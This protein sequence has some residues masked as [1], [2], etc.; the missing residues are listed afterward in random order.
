M[1]MLLLFMTPFTAPSSPPSAP[2]LL[3][4]HWGHEMPQCESKANWS[5]KG[6][7]LLLAMLLSL[8]NEP[9]STFA[10][11]NVASRACHA[12]LVAYA[13]RDWIPR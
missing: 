4:T 5:G 10:G 8:Q 13:G 3:R 11:V 9:R 7:W 6:C 2:L 1:L 12:E